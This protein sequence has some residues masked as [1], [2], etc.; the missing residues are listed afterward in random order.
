MM[1]NTFVFYLVS[2]GIIWFTKSRGFWLQFFAGLF[3]AFLF[4][5]S[6]PLTLVDLVLIGFVGFCL[7]VACIGLAAN[8]SYVATFAAAFVLT[9]CFWIVKAGGLYRWDGSIF[10]FALP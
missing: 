6:T 1:S 7:G 5:S 9:V 4:V 10:S 8:R 3:F 2:A